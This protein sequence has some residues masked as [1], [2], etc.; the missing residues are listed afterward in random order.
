MVTNAD[1]DFLKMTTVK[2]NKTYDD[3]IRYYIHNLHGE[4]QPYDILNAYFI[5][6]L[7]KKIVSF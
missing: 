2:H 4:K 6:F 1:I 7:Q 5:I 3:I